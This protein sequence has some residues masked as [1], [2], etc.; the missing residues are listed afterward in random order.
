MLLLPVSMVAIP[1]TVHCA[2]R[3]SVTLVWLIVKL[4]AANGRRKDRGGGGGVE[5]EEERK[6]REYFGESIVGDP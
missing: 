4:L 1:S 3:P 6:R 2:S 5:K